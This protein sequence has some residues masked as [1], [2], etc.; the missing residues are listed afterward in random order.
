MH[1]EHWKYVWCPFNSETNFNSPKQ[2]LSPFTERKK[3]KKLRI[4]LKKNLWKKTNLAEID[5]ELYYNQREWFFCEF[6]EISRYTF[7]HRT[8]L[9]AASVRTAAIIW[10]FCQQLQQ[11]SFANTSTRTN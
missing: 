10:G 7:L 4:R 8:P 11:N 3:Q 9:V 6:S 5:G 2:I 1:R